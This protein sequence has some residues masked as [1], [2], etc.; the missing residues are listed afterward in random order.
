MTGPFTANPALALEYSAGTLT[1]YSGM[2]GRPGTSAA[3]GKAF[4]R[5]I[6]RFQRAERARVLDA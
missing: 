3:V 1:I 2:L 5:T 6:Y 4:L